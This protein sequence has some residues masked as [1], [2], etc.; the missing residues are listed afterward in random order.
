MQVYAFG[1]TIKPKG[2]FH[3]AG[4]KLNVTECERNLPVLLSADGTKH[5]QVNSAASKTNRVLRLMKSTFCY[6]SDEIVRSIYPKF[7]RPY[8]EFTS[9]VWNQNLEYYYSK[10][11]ESVQRR[12]TTLTKEPYHL[13]YEKRL[14]RQGLTI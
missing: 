14:K 1:E 6:W 2:L 13:P 11:I 12:A 7:V 4:I 8:L 9:S 5:K 10:S 3:C